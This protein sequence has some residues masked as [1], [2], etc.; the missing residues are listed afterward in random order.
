M[1]NNTLYK[2]NRHSYYNLNYH[3]V[4]VTKYRHPVLNDD[5]DKRLK[6]IVMNV[7]ETKW[8]SKIIKVETNMDHI[9]ILFEAQPQVQLS[10]LINNF[11]TVSSRLIRKEFS[12]Y[13]QPYYWKP[14][15]WSR[16]YYIGAV[17]DTTE[18]VVKAYIENQKK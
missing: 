17:S 5:I 12:E 18:E 9:H 8:G 11:K 13:L 16:S 3:L 15:F 7:F 4:V 10:T 14:Y 6:E 1:S 2:R